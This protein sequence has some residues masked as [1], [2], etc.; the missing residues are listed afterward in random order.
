MRHVLSAVLVVL[1][2][3]PSTSRAQ[4][5]EAP[6]PR[7]VSI[8]VADLSLGVIGLGYAHVVSPEV[9]LEG[10]AHY[11]QPWY[12]ADSVFGAG[13]EARIYLHPY[14]DAPEGFYVAAGVRLDWVH[15][16][17]T[18]VTRDGFGTSIR[19]SCGAAFLFFD[20][21]LMRLGAGGQIEIAELSE[22]NASFLEAR[23]VLDIYAALAF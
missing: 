14:A 16:E 21:F 10:V 15:D 7:K 9:V 4:P 1:M 5:Q 20:L 8:V 18:A 22:P 12:H 13:G 17:R 23:P 11:Y 2:L 6:E 3:V 19:I